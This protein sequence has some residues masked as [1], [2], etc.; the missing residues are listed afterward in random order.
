MSAVGILGGLFDPVH[1]GHL[2]VA[3]EVQEQLDL[4]EVRLVPCGLPPHRPA[5]IASGTQRLAMT[6]AAIAGQAGLSVDERELRRP[7]LS[8][9][10]DTL[11]S[12]RAELGDV[13]LCLI[14]GTDAFLGLPSWQRWREIPAL[15]HLVVVHRPGWVQPDNG[16]CAPEIEQLLA[17]HRTLDARALHERPAG[18]VLF[19]P[20]T[21]LGI[22]STQIRQLV[23]AGRSPRYLVPDAVCDLM[24]QERIYAQA[25][26]ESKS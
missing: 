1:L 3:L 19:Q 11:G 16:A 4:T 8:Y 17:T 23:A 2:R 15:A 6:Q 5:P 14:L 12:L 20:V 24:R 18:C 9:M 7:G 22:S 21:P 25:K 13:P 26:A 10:V